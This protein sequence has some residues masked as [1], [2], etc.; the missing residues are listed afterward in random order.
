M[1]IKKLGDTITEIDGKVR[2]E[3]GH[4]RRTEVATEE[5]LSNEVTA[6]HYAVGLKDALGNVIT[7]GKSMAYIDWLAPDRVFYVYRLEEVV[8]IVDGKKVKNQ[9]WLPNGDPFADEAAALSHATTLA[10]ELAA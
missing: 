2:I 5:L 9:R 8:D 6:A 10:A 4:V 1:D 7:L 3:I